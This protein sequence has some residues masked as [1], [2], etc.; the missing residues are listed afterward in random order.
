[1][2]NRLFFFFFFVTIQSVLFSQNTEIGLL[3]GASIYTGD[4]EVSP[5]NFLPQTRPAV[6]IFGRQHFSEKLAVRALFAIGGVT[7]DEKKY[8]TSKELENRGF[9]FKGTVAELA[10][11]PE[12]RPFNIGNVD[13]YA[14]L[15]LAATY[16]NPKSNF[17]DKGS[18]SSDPTIVEDQN[19]KYPKIALSMPFGGGLQWNINQ[20]TALGA[21]LGLRKTF[22]D[23]IDGLSASANAKSTDFYFL[24]GITFSKFFSLGNDRS[25]TKRTRYQRRGVNCPTFN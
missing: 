18:S 22:T 6:G 4:I 15:G 23:Y 12:W 14:F 3:V 16:M 13:F 5:R 9:N 20:T 25:G 11:L 19:Q 7:G 1:M 24:G 21:E 8:P 10:L 17:N 2:K